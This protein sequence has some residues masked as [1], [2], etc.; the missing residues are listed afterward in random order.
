M[1]NF[2]KSTLIA[3]TVLSL[4]VGSAFQSNA[5]TQ[6]VNV[7]NNVFT[8]SSFT[9]NLGD[10][11]KWVWVAGSHTTTSQTIPGGAA[12]WNHNINSS[13]GNTSFI[14]VPT[15]LGTYN[16]HCSIHSATMLG[17]FTVVCPTASVTISAGGATT[18][19]SGGNVVLS[20]SSVPTFTSYQWN[21]NGT[22]ITAATTTSYTATS[23][24]SYTLKVTNSCGNTATSSAIAVT[25][26]AAPTSTD[27][28]I[29]AS[30][31][32]TFCSGGSVTLSV[33]TAGLTYLWSNGATTQNIVISVSGNY[34]CTVSNSCG[35]IVSNTIS[36][37]VNAAPT[38]SEATITAG[39]STT[40]C[41]G[42]SVTLSVATAG[43]T[44]LW[45]N[46]ATT[47]SITTSVAGNY[48]C[49]VSNSCG[50]TISNT[51]SV[52]VNTAPTAAQAT[53]TAAGPTSFCG[54]TGVV[55]SVATSGLTYQWLK[56]GANIS[57]QTSQSY[58]A[59][60]TAT[61]SCNVSNSCGTTTSNTIDA[62][63]NTAPTSTVTQAPC[64]GG[65][66]LLTCTPTPTTGIT[67]E[68]KK[69]SKVQAGATN[70]TFS[71][72][73]DGTYKCTVTITATGCTKTS[74]GSVVTITCKSGIDEAENKI[75]AYPN[76]ASDY[77]NIN[78]SSLPD[79]SSISV[80]D[81]A[82]NLLETYPSI[83]NNLKV[84]SSLSAGVYFAKIECE[85]AIIKVI[86]LVK[87]K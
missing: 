35:S 26:N 4:L 29:T 2:S 36:V 52:T 77:F 74:S 25:V 31:A 69:G 23:T 62:V 16:Y 85:G 47:Q 67:F 72:T 75:I 1:K 42:G 41:S 60:A 56:N 6:S 55:L 27:A 53:I 82:G 30:G 66:V 76:P 3:I 9:I 24:G 40:F 70:S 13:A 37:T 21:L 83:N 17:S 63:K 8:P 73:K 79:A 7:S 64:S 33:A 38:A 84:G 51:I 49:T 57:G 48:S 15:V 50:S 68:W 59:K 32:T 20:K 34:S 10:T 58:T 43:L 61:F 86:K 46:G 18:F 12:T 54:T 87:S 11:V 19:C 81:L 14:Y 65:E 45:S 80:Y 39:G 22:A 71:A 44:Y 5:T 78:T 28:N